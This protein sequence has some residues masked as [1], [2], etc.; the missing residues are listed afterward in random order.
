MLKQHFSLTAWFATKDTNLGF[1]LGMYFSRKERP[2]Y[3]TAFFIDVK[4]LLLYNNKQTESL[5]PL[6][7]TVSKVVEP[8]LLSERKFNSFQKYWNL[9]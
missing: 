8:I 7:K 4:R 5:Q 9:F 1:S 6:V 3:G 2:F